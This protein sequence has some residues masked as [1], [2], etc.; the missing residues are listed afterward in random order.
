VEANPDASGNVERA[1][2]QAARELLLLESSDWPFLVT[3]GQA[4][5][6]ATKRFRE[7]VA[8]FE[9]LAEMVESGNIDQTRLTELE[10]RDN[11]FANIDY[12]DFAERQGKAEYPLAG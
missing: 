11:P 8:R 12:H 4:K 1:L 6:Y 7:H 5:E 3:P 9:E 10:N 2:E